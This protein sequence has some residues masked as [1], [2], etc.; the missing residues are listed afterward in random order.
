MWCCLLTAC[1]L[2]SPAPGGPA[3]NDA[4]VTLQ[5]WQSELPHWVIFI[6]CPYDGLWF[7]SKAKSSVNIMFYYVQDVQND[8]IHWTPRV[9]MMTTLSSLVATL[10]VIMTTSCSQCF[11]CRWD[12]NNQHQHLETSPLPWLDVGLY[13]YMHHNKLIITNLLTSMHHKWK[14][15]LQDISHL[16]EK[17]I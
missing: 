12:S 9:V 4:L 8:F 13:V 16:Y 10:D 1:C 14:E 7:W 2:L 17:Y 5:F 15:I 6:P 3:S 11:W